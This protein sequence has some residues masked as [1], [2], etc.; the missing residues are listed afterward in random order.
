[1]SE[2]DDFNNEFESEDY[3][4]EIDAEAAS[5][6]AR[7]RLRDQ[8]ASDVEAFLSRGGKIQE[9]EQGFQ[10]DPPRKPES[11]YGSQPI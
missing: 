8:M 2:Q 1:M 5:I 10:A 11:K 6:R 3:D 4:F 7:E 9:V